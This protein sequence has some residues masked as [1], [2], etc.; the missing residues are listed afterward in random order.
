[1]SD[2][3]NAILKASPPSRT[4]PAA[5]SAAFTSGNDLTPSTWGRGFHATS[6]GNV[7]ITMPDGSTPTFAVLAGCFYPYEV[8]SIVGSGTNV[9]GYVLF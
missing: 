6:A 5:G 7:K 8:V 3:R 1:M 9:N 2:A 4:E